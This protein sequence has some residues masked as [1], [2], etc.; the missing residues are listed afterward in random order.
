[1]KAYTPEHSEMRHVD[2]ETVRR[3]AR[4]VRLSGV[5]LRRAVGMMSTA[6]PTLP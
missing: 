1:M 5:R 6:H 2:T 4:A 3:R